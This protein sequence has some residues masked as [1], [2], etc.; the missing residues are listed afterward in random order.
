VTTQTFLGG[1]LLAQ[2]QGSTSSFPLTDALR[3]V[4]AT[5]NSSGAIVAT[6]RY[7]AYGAARATTG[8]GGQFGFTGQ[9]TDPTGL[10]NL[11]ARMYRPD[12]GRFLSVDP[13]QRDVQESTGGWGTVAMGVR[14]AYCG[15][16]PVTSFQYGNGNPTTAT[17][18]SG[19][20]TE[21]ELRSM[22]IEDCIRK[23]IETPGFVQCIQDCNAFVKIVRPYLTIG[24]VTGAALGLLGRAYVL[25]SGLQ[26][27]YDI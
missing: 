21:E 14:P 22:C 24:I 15:G 12:T 5:T 16:G 8:I 4:R 25:S 26:V 1:T 2:T 19:K 6:A 13:L 11:R 17:D 7:D 10:I 27:A 9:Q 23:G 3:S 20:I 18:P